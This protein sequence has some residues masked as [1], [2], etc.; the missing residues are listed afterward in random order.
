MK[1]PYISVEKAIDIIIYRK[2]HKATLK[3]PY[4]INFKNNK[5]R[6]KQTNRIALQFLMNAIQLKNLNHPETEECPTPIDITSIISCYLFGSIVKPEYNK[7]IKRYLFGLF[8]TEKE[9]RIIS[10]DIDIICFTNGLYE[11][12]HIKSISSW[13]KTISTTY[14][15]HTEKKYCNFDISFIPRHLIK[16]N[17]N[18]EFINHIKNYGVC[19]MGENILE[20]TK[21]ATWSHDTIKDKILCFIPKEPNVSIEK[22]T[23]IEIE[24]KTETEKKC[25]LID[26][27]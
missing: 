15:H 10:N 8:T 13:E 16:N 22:E 11:K 21:Y 26:L 5:G 1:N 27:E 14:G 17:E 20:T 25:N 12:K 3:F 9:K 23:E 7:I 24:K 2:D 6:T 18:Q 19:I 4:K